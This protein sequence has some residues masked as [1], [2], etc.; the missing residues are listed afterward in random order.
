MNFFKSRL[1]N[2]N[3]E[4]KVVSKT[5]KPHGICLCNIYKNYLQEIVL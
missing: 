3:L 1:F 4:E 5:P 2:D